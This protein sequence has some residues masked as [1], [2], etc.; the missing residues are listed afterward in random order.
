VFDSRRALVLDANILIR[1]VLGKRVRSL[2]EQHATQVFL[3]TPDLCFGEAESYLP[4]IIARRGGDRE[5]ATVLLAA[6]SPFIA[7]IGVSFY[8]PYYEKAQER[9]SVRDPNDWHVVATALL[10]D[11][12]IW[13]ED[14]DFFGAGIA[15]WTT[16]RV[17]LYL[18][19]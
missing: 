15:T 10:L 8:E 12:P 9:I 2:I 7:E 6:L 3:C 14:K 13:T 11:C 5:S 4:E 1:A 17:H 18:N 19:G 16:D